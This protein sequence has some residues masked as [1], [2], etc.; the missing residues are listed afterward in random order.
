[1]PLRAERVALIAVAPTTREIPR[2][3]WRT[4]FDDFS[5]DN[6][7]LRAAVEVDGVEVGAQVQ[8]ERAL[9]RG[10]TYDHGDDILVI[11]LG[12]SGEIGEDLEHVVSNPQ[13]I[14]LAESDGE[15]TFDIKDAEGTQ[16]LLRLTPG[17]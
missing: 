15:L 10:I 1:M 13:S 2:S 17:A 16:T 7:R 14:Y 3:E 8:T 11:G 9:L 5:R 4:Y 12:A 6:D